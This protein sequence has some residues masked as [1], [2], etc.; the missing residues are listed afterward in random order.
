MI[1]LA[2]ITTALA[3]AFCA[4]AAQADP[5]N[6]LSFD[7][8]M[9]CTTDP[10]AATTVP[11]WTIVAGS[12]ALDCANATPAHW[13]AANT[14]RVVIASGPWGTSTLE[15]LIPLEQTAAGKPV[16]FVLSGL[17]GA[18]GDGQVH[19]VLDAQFLDEAGRKIG[20]SGALTG[21]E[22]Q[23]KDKSIQ[24]ALLTSSG[25]IPRKARTLQLSLHLPGI[26][27]PG[28]T[29]GKVATYVAGLQLQ[30]DPALSFP[31]VTAPDAHVPRFD[32]V[33]L[34]IMEN[35]DYTQ[36][37]G[38]KINAPY[39]NQLA[40]RG[41]LLA[42]YQAV[43]HPSDENYMAIAGGE[44][45]IVGPLYFP[46]IHIA[47]P[48]LGDLLEAAG[49]SWKTYE[50]GMGTPCNTTTKFDKNYEPDDTPFINF[51]NIQN[52]PARCRAHMVDLSEWAKDLRS[53]AT[54]PAFAWLAADDYNDGELPGNGSPKSLRVQDQWLKVTLAP[55]F[56]SSAWRNQKSL[57]IL[58]WDESDTVLNNHI[59]TIV[60]GSQGMVK[61][62]YVSQ[63][64]YDHYSSART[65]EAALGLPNL[66]SNDGFATAIDD[67]FTANR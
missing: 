18:L 67:A 4:Q 1:R 47:A 55:L 9:R 48:H 53:P 46:N 6:P 45:L 7:K 65:I 64:R 62:G 56:A 57:L 58:T 44:G 41:T 34:I 28:T 35:T 31:P 50:E 22:P 40:A 30:T 14:P 24:F 23:A 43:Y 42:N 20:P 63:R 49:K 2:S 29:N 17:F 8:A 11:G 51:T 15:R 66:T 13:P 25:V 54:T 37:I 19:A 10:A 59:A 38:D 16:K 5:A 39:M 32:H 12:P 26:P 3:I 27:Q 52:N 61:V 33:F 21:P 36:V 60:I